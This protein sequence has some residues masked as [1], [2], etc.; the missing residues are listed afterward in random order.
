M[1][2]TF[3]LGMFRVGFDTFAL[4][5]NFIDDFWVLCHITIK[6]FEAP[7]NFGITLAKIVKPLLRKFQMTNKIVFYVKDEGSNLGTFD[8]VLTFV[9]NR[10]L[11]DLSK[12]YIGTCFGH[13][14]S[15]CCQY[16]TSEEKVCMDMK[17]VLLKDDQTSLQKT[18]IWTK[19]FGKGR[20]EWDKACIEVGLLAR[21]L[22]TLMKIRFTSKVV[23]FQKMLEIIDI[24]NIYYQ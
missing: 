13:L 8:S 16:M 12:P 17:E 2:I 24:V 9:V 21:K 11:L 14:M 3:D 22:K 7:N 15:K 10:E 4:V 19:K 23:L 1:S 18:I 20:E 5:V 6:L